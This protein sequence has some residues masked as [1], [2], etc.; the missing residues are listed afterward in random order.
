MYNGIAGEYRMRGFS[1][2][3]YSGIFFINSPVRT[4][5]ESLGTGWCPK[6]I[7]HKYGN[8]SYIVKK[9]ENSS[10]CV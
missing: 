2:W 5:L 10:K 4:E 3:K 6:K 7:T 1:G 9:K 8:I